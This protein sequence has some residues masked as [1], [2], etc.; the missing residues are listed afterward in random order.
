M[1]MR[2]WLV[3]LIAVSSFSGLAYAQT[4]VEP[5]QFQSNAEEQRFHDL[6][7]ELRCVMCQNQS[8]ADSNAQIAV[9]LR[10]EVLTLMREGRSDDEVK[11]YLVQRY[12][13]FVLYRPVVSGRNIALWVGPF[14]LLAIALA[15]LWFWR[16]QHRPVA[17]SESALNNDQKDID[18]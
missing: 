11:A 16:R 9:E 1:M 8:L 6:L 5:P 13:E 2:F 4:S 18:W 14:A 3:L 7:A 10:K 12:G 15:G 17:V